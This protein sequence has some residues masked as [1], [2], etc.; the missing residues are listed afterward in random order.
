MKYKNAFFCFLALFLASADLSSTAES[1]TVSIKSGQIQN[2]V[3]SSLK[4]HYLCVLTHAS[5]N[6]IEMIATCKEY[7]DEI[8]RSFAWV[9]RQLK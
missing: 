4:R 9:C 3:N 5:T 8:R 2:Y 6:E 1:I 7:A